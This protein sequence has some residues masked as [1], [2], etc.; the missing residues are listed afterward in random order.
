[1]S[2]YN[3]KIG[4]LLA[5]LVVA[6]TNHTNPTDPPLYQHTQ[7]T[8]H[9]LEDQQNVC[10][11]SFIA[12]VTEKSGRVRNRKMCND[13]DVIFT[14][15]Q[16]IST[17]LPPQ[18]KK[19]I[20]NILGRFSRV[21]A[22]N[23]I[24]MVKK[25]SNA[26]KSKKPNGFNIDREVRPDVLEFM[27]KPPGTRVSWSSLTSCIH[28]YIKDHSL[29]NPLVRTEIIPDQRLGRLLC[30]NSITDPKLEYKTMQKLIAKCFLP[31]V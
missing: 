24:A 16:L 17:Q 22:A 6:D 10:D 13:L 15:L 1:M 2:G 20:T 28:A 23:K 8:Q 5:D 18:Y 3:N 7:H 26:N 21:I 25:A 19:P 27:D 4:E 29:Q 14:D 9:T 30:Y 12:D 31:R 11:T